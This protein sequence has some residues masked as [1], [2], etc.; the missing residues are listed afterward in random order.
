MHRFSNRLAVVLF[1]ALPLAACKD[2]AKDVGKAQVTA[3]VDSAKTPA[4]SGEVLPIDAKSSKIEFTGSKVTGSHT[5][6]FSKFEGKVDL[7]DGKPEQSTVS[8]DVDLA[9]VDTDEA[10]LTK[11]LQSGDFFDVP[12]HPKAT[13]VSTKIEPLP[14]GGKGTHQV[15]GNLELRGVTKSISFPATIAV[16]GDAVAADADFSID[17]TQWG[18]TYKGMADNLIRN[19]VVIKF[20]VRAPRN[21][22]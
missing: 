14:A 19:D 2:P 1:A 13:F 21:K 3:P 18:I 16:T 5:G 22:G 12:A 10:K 6:H 9:S 20:S 7:V 8:F 4:K 11:H 17:R 15:T